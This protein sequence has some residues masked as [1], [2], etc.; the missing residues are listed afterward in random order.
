MWFLPT[1][2]RAESL[3]KVI[4]ACVD[5]AMSTPVCVLVQYGQ[6]KSAY[7]ELELPPNWTIVHL[8][9][10]MGMLGARNWALLQYPNEP[11]YGFMCDDNLPRTN[12]WDTKLVEAAG[13]KRFVS[14]SDLFRAPPRAGGATV[15]GGDLLRALG[16]WSLPGLWHWFDDDF[17][18]TLGTELGL[19]TIVKDVV[20]ETVHQENGKMPVDDTFLLG[21]SRA[22]QD[23]M[24]YESWKATAKSDT[25]AKLA[26]LIDISPTSQ[27]AAF[28]ANLAGMDIALATPCH[29]AQ[30]DERY[31]QSMMMTIPLILQHGASFGFLTVCGES[32]V[33]RARNHL[34]KRFLE[35]PWTHLMFI[36]ADMGWEPQSV[37]R[38][39]A[40]GKEFVG[41]AGPRK[42]EP[43]SF[44]CEL[45][46]PF[47]RC[48][49][50]GLLKGQH[51]GAAFT[52]IQR[53]VLERMTAAYEN[54]KYFDVQRQEWVVPLYDTRTEN[55]RFW[56]E[57]Y[58]FCHR[59][60]ALGGEVWL[61]PM[62]EMEHV[63]RKV[64]KGA[65]VQKLA[66]DAEVMRAAQVTPAPAAPATPAAEPAKEAAD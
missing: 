65:L 15:F 57:D 19:W 32:I 66:A 13:N 22:R 1:L 41:A 61:D 52:L 11:W 48:P 20:V 49:K 4:K 6:Q 12:G 27:G 36:D 26:S 51:V 50:T 54:L 25:Y 29:T 40:S 8:P 44:A 33:Q 64:F 10:N 58:T 18:E 42:Q 7:D 17:W 34:V 63:G 39:M 30:F 21:Q 31:V 45:E 46:Q 2:N 47:Q 37:L 53:S 62:I 38:L 60:K 56:S 23:Q 5:T 55:H 24:V 43:V 9:V 14:C 59:W 35:G 28:T 16:F 3:R